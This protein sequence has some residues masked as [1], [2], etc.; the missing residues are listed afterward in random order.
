VCTG[1]HH[2]AEAAFGSGALGIDVDDALNLRV[3]E[4]ESV[5]RTISTVHKGLR[6]SA[7]VETLDAVLAI[8]AAAEK[9]DTGIGMVRV[10]LSN[11]LVE[12]LI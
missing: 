11:F 6:E 5:N 12:A 10:E 3:V 2:A 9:L 4:E 8:I 1:R 7:N